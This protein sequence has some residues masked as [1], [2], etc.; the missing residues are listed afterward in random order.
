MPYIYL[1][2]INQH[3]PI[4]LFRDLCSMQ[5]HILTSGIAAFV[6]PRI[7]RVLEPRYITFLAIL[8]KGNWD[9]P[10]CQGPNNKKLT[11]D[12]GTEQRDRVC[13]LCLY[14]NAQ[15]CVTSITENEI[16]STKHVRIHRLS[17][18]LSE[19]GSFPRGCVGIET[20]YLFGET[21]S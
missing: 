18:A 13:R 15:Q 9:S 5:Y 20:T 8:N 21:V 17:L 14:P 6:C 7:R 11:V 4:N 10:Y 19:T 12:C 16:S 1:Y 3:L 2:V